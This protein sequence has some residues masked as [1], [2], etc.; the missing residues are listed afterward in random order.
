MGDFW[1]IPKC[2]PCAAK[3]EGKEKIENVNVSIT[4]KWRFNYKGTIITLLG[5]QNIFSN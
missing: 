4:L 1:P 3:M 5:C 2:C